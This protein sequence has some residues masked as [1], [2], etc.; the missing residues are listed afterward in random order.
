MLCIVSF[1]SLVWNL[2]V[3][4][5]TSVMCFKLKYILKQ[6][7]CGM[8]DQIKRLNYNKYDVWFSELYR[9]VDSN[10]FIAFLA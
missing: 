2:S 9:I 7:K 8:M 10:V 5:I 3:F 6:Y 1:L 4:G